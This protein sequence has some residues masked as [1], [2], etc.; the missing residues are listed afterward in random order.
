MIWERDPLFAKSRLFF[1]R[2]FAEPAESPLFGLW[3]SLGLELLARAALASISPTLLAESDR[4]HRFLLHALN[5]GNDKSPPQSISTN[6]V[7][8]LCLTLFEKFTKESFTASIALANRRNA[9]L[10]SAEAAFDEYPSRIWLPGF[11]R[12][13]DVLATILGESLEVLFGAEQAANARE[14]LTETQNEVL[15]RVQGTIAA[16]RRVF[17][18]KAEE[19]RERLK[20]LVAVETERLSHQRH[21]KVTC[22]A[23]GC[24]AT[25]QGDVFGPKK[26]EIEDEEI[27]VRES[28]SPKLFSC[29]ACGL[30]LT[31]YAEISAAGFGGTY[32]RRTTFTPEEFYGLIDPTSEAIVPYIEDYLADMA[33]DNEYDN[34]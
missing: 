4:D 14:I 10:H 31:G 17:E 11:Y 30:R 32:T 21:H 34:E 27:V 5:K 22:P 25:L 3:C 19:E 1:E 12:A 20:E 26:A 29:S 7:F 28:V 33:A 23:C 15:G 24:D 2:A 8:T 9:E 6:Q 16:H 13:A 18:G